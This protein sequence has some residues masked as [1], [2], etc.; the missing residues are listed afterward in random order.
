VLV[1]LSVHIQ[2]SDPWDLGEAIAWRPLFG[3]V[4]DDE[5]L[6]IELDAP[7]IVNGRPINWLLGSRRDGEEVGPIPGTYNLIGVDRMDAAPAVVQARY[8]G[9][10][11]GTAMIARITLRGVQ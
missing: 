9:P 2:L 10:A 11:T 3:V 8:R 7:L 4:R 1:A 5:P 6:T